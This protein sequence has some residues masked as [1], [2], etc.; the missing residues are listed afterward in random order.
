[1]KNNNV[2]NKTAFARE[3]YLQKRERTFYEGE[4][5]YVI[6]VKPLLVIKT[7]KGVVC[8]ALHKYLNVRE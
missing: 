4:Q 7:K 5:A 3:E 1:M 2:D 8:G 6:R